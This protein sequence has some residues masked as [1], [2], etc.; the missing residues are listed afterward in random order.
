MFYA[1]IGGHLEE[2]ETLTKCAQR[3]ANEEVGV[4]VKLFS[5][6][7]TYYLPDKKDIQEI[8]VTNSPQPLALY[9]MIYPQ[10]VQNQG[11]SYY[12]VIYR[13][14]FKEIP[15][16][17]KKDEVVGLVGLTEE[18]IIKNINRKPTLEELIEEGAITTGNIEDNIK[19]TIMYP[20]GT[21]KAIENI[22]YKEKN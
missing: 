6:S 7:K 2:G 13:A 10:G 20:I 9:E 4:G 16:C 15:K 3:E 14:Q 17:F 18:Q 19:N 22:L 12:I 5:S 11:E 8:K 21:A 1:G